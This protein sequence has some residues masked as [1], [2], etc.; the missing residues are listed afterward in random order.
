MESGVLGWYLSLT[1]PPGTPPRFVFGPVWTVL[2]ILIGIAG[3]LVWRRVGAAAM[4]RRPLRLWGWQLLANALWTPAFFGLRNTSAGLAVMLALLALV[5]LT[6]RDFARVNRLAAGLFA[7]YA[8]W[9]TYA[10]YLN[11]GF[12]WL[13]GF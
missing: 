13:N 12:W 3:W 4:L 2:Y 8:L 6:M 10:A 11:L 5:L 7:P 1:A 9:V